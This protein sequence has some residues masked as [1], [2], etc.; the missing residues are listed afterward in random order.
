LNINDIK[1][2]DST[3]FLINQ[4]IG[5]IEHTQKHQNI[6]YCHIIA[7]LTYVLQHHTDQFIN[8][9]SIDEGGEDGIVQEDR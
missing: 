8:S 3:N 1:T 2:W 5:S 9:V 7:A 4:I 6:E